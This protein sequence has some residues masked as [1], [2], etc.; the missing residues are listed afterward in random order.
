MTRHTITGGAGFIGSGIAK[1][2]VRRGDD[3]TVIDDLS[4]GDVSNIEH[5]KNVRFIKASIL[6]E[7]AV[8]DAIAGADT[9]FHLAASVG[10]KRSIDNPTLDSQINVLGTI[11]VL[12]ATRKAGVKKI[13]ISSSAGI[14]GELERFPISEDHPVEPDSPY[15]VSKLAAEKLCLAYSKLYDMEAIALRYFN[16]YGPNQRFDAYGNVVPIFVFKLLSGEPITIFGDGE[17]TRDF[18][19]VHDV[20]QANIAAA[21][22]QGVTGAFNIASGTEI[23]INDLVRRITTLVPGDNQVLTGNQ[24]PGDVLRSLGD[25]S[26]ARSQIGYE[27]SVDIDKGLAE[28]VDW[29]RGELSK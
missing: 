15:G 1:S 3:V 25:I 5:L 11:N 8:A 21:D 23:T 29:A 12:E 2:L 9:V 13:V 20:V 17:Q 27:P 7:I 19:S 10:N 6:S 28:Y 14:F 22:A 16:V 26:K 4:S 24:R 18:V